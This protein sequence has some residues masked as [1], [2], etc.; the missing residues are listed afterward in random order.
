M[1]NKLI[2]CSLLFINACDA[3]P[4]QN[5]AA[6]SQTE[7]EFSSTQLNTCMYKTSLYDVKIS[8]ESEVVSDDE[9]TIK[10][11]TAKVNNVDQ[12]LEVSPDTS[13]LDGDLGYISFADINFDKV[14]DLAL[15]TSFGTPNLYLDYWVYDSKQ[16]KYI[17][18]GNYPKFTINE[19]KKTLSATIKSNAENYHNIE[20]HWNNN[21]LEK[22]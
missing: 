19:Q 6:A 5:Q 8:I 14:P 16:K 12:S 11:I 2:L 18:V 20:W 21:T 9:K 17:S 7:C 3:Q 10:K 4:K 22:K 15:T 1:K 13:I